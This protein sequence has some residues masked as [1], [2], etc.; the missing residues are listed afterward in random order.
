MA[1]K[2]K[3]IKARRSY[4]VAVVMSCLGLIALSA[5]LIAVILG[6]QPRIALTVSVS[7]YGAATAALIIV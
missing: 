5:S 7:V 2:N 6:V 3:K 1:E 4:V